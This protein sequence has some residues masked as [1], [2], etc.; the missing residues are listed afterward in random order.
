MR[1]AARS[2]ASNDPTTGSPLSSSGPHTARAPSQIRQARLQNRAIQF[3]DV[4]RTEV[5]TVSDGLGQEIRQAGSQL[6]AAPGAA[7]EPNGAAGGVLSLLSDYWWIEIALGIAWLVISVVV[8]KFTHASVITVGVLTGIMFLLFGLEEFAL[9]AVDRS[10]RWLW[11]IFG[12]LLFAA[13]IV[14]LIHPKE[15]FAGFA[16]ILGFVFLLLGTIWIVQA[17][18][19]RVFNRAWWLGLISGILMVVAAFWVTGEFFFERAYTLL[20]FAGVWA[21]AKGVTDIVR[22]FELRG[23]RS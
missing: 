18:A 23:L 12:V 20:I 9:A 3:N 4:Q 8:L 19:E 14:S 13:G 7:R 17:F 11:A 2:Q 10:T 22:G 15:T 5:N 21:L 16:E 1:M 6:F